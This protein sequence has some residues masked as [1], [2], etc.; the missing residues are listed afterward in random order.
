MNETLLPSDEILL[1]YASG[2][3][4]VGVRLLVDAH[5]EKLPACRARLDPFDAL[6]GEMV[7]R[8][9]TAAL[10]PDA[11]SRALAAIAAPSAPD[12]PVRTTVVDRL[13]PGAWRW[14]GPGARVAPVAV[15]GART[16]LFLMQ[17]APGR[18][19]PEHGHSGREFTVVLEGAYRDELGIVEAGAFVEMAPEDRHRPV[20]EGDAACV[21]LFA[22]E[23]PI[24]ARGL[25]GVAARWAM[26]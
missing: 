24:A 1:K 20:V 25:V 8:T 26:R 17:I 7:R 10:R 23:S 6:A 2:A 13:R 21:C 16:R 15:S 11:L 12:E 22:L 19:M 18:A 3:L 5:F 4:D 14:A 9:P